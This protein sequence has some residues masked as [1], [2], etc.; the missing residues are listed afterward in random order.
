MVASIKKHITDLYDKFTT[1]I[2]V[3]VYVVLMTAVV[4]VNQIPEKYKYYG[5]N[6]IL[7]LVLFGTT[8]AIC[9]YISYSHAMLFA[10]FVV[11]Y[12][13]FTPG[14]RE[15]FQNQIKQSVDCKK[16]WWD[17]IILGVCESELDNQKVTTL[18]PGT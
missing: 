3:V 1:P 13:S 8:L 9:D 2:H 15:A 4:Y 5:N 11:L 12:I 18:A 17:E 6:L 16:P 10:L 7:R 14:F